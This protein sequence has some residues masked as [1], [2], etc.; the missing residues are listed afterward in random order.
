MTNGM[1]DVASLAGVAIGTVSNVLNHPDPF[2]TEVAR[3]AEDYAQHA[4]LADH[5][6]RSGAKRLEWLDP[7]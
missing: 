6:Q 2:F 7:N 1:K 5:S 3:G 4:G